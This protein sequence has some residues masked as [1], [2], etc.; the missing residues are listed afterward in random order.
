MKTIDHTA[1][2]EFYQKFGTAIMC[3]AIVQLM[4]NY[5]TLWGFIS[6]AARKIIQQDPE[7]TKE[8]LEPKLI[9]LAETINEGFKDPRVKE[10]LKQDIHYKD[11]TEDELFEIVLYNVS[12]A[13]LKES[14][15]EF[16]AI[17]EEVWQGIMGD[18]YKTYDLDI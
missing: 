13:L 16:S 17:A 2:Q 10:R 14:D 15:N 3:T 6:D 4:Y 1:A 11:K 7:K 18:I 12:N 5:G 9:A 8:S